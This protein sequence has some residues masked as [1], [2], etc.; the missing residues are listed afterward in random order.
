[1]SFK[2]IRNKA[3]TSK[4]G[5]R[6]PLRGYEP[7]TSVDG[8][9]HRKGIASPKTMALMRSEF[10]ARSFEK[11][12]KG[13][14]FPDWVSPKDVWLAGVQE[15]RRA[16]QPSVHS[17]EYRLRRDAMAF[18]Y[19]IK[20][21]KSNI[22]NNNRQLNHHNKS[23]NTSCA[24]SASAVMLSNQQGGGGGVRRSVSGGGKDGGKIATR[25]GYLR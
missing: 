14:V 15:Q 18:A 10:R 5:A 25:T 16:M 23:N 17:P 13:E 9:P 12:S 22:K 8:T 19:R 20:R 21:E 4:L 11:V 3:W 24:V 1:M 6:S 7:L 2:F